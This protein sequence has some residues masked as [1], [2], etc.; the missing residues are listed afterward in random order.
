M[1]LRGWGSGLDVEG[2][3][4]V[5]GGVGGVEGGGEEGGMKPYVT[6]KATNKPE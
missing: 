5:W 3:G 1:G 4:L 6:E 2:W